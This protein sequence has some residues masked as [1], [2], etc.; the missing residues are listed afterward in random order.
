MKFK[1]IAG[2]T[3]LLMLLLFLAPPVIKL[4]KIALAVVV[5]IGVAM[6]AY[7]FYEQLRGKED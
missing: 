7:E 3:G 4:Q 1:S 5:L 2:L 6:A